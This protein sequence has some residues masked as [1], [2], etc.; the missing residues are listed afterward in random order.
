MPKSGG[1]DVLSRSKTNTEIKI[2]RLKCPSS[3]W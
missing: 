2:G 1:D 3:K